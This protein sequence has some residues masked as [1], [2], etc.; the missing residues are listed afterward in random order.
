[1]KL[2]NPWMLLLVPIVAAIVWWAYNRNKSV[3]EGIYFPNASA[4]RD[5][6]HPWVQRWTTAR[7]WIRLAVITFVLLA[8]VRPQIE[9]TQSEV[10]EPGVDIVIAMDVSGSMAA[11]DFSPDNRLVAAKNVAR[12]FILSRPNDRIGMV[13][14]G[15]FALTQCPL[16]MDRMVL[17]TL[18]DKIQL[19]EAGEDTAIGLGLATAVNRLKN[20]DAK[21]K[22]VILIT[23]G[24]N[25][26]GGVLPEVAARAAHSARIRVYT[27]GIGREGGAPIPHMDPVKGKVY[28]TDQDGAPILTEIDEASL[29]QIA[30]T[31]GGRYFRATDE[32]V[33][34]SVYNTI[35]SLEKT[36]SK[37]KIYHQYIELFPLLLIMA[38]ILLVVELCLSRLVWRTLP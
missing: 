38:A 29:K 2:A 26:A 8:L 33:L 28:E 10:T 4:I 22:I 17:T 7:P 15:T 37:V 6:A 19:A 36:P 23:D 5:L 24:V 21:S 31:T 9:T 27:I 13:I 12:E 30:V 18:V 25:N 32:K 34:K 16:T 1:M 35:D 3:Q 14:F 11:E 20:S